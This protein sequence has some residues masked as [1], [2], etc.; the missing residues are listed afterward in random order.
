LFQY[1]LKYLDWRCHNRLKASGARLIFIL[2]LYVMGAAIFQ[3]NE[4]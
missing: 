2:E 3:V 4:E 1:S